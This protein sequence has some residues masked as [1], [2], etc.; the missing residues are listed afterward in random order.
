[1]NH[2]LKSAKINKELKRHGLIIQINTYLEDLS[3]N[4]LCELIRCLRLIE[5]GKHE[6]TL[7]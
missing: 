2:E 6:R 7:N 4:E 3:Y 1:M 5:R